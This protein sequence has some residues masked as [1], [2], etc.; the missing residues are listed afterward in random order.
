M[1]CLEIMQQGRQRQAVG[2]VVLLV[3]IYR[4]VHHGKEGVGIHVLF[5]ADFPYRLVAESQVD[6]EATQALQDIV[7]VSNDADHLVVSLIHLLIFHL[8][9]SLNANILVSRT[10]IMFLFWLQIYKKVS[11]PAIPRNGDAEIYRNLGIARFLKTPY[12]C[13]RNRERVR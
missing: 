13:T 12:L 10:F 4:K 1:R 8:V 3:T 6:A 9:L 5:V 7:I 11:K 2:I